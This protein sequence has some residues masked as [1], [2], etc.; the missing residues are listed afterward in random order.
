[1]VGTVMSLAPPATAWPA[2]WTPL[3]TVSREVRTVRV[4]RELRPPL[5]S[6]ARCTAL[7]SHDIAP[8]PGRRPS[9][10]P[11]LPPRTLVDINKRRAS[12]AR[13]A[14][15]RAEQMRRCRGALPVPVARCGLRMRAPARNLDNGH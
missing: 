15:T 13:E 12:R 2:W 7:R 11:P 14:G 1:V 9:A 5:A 8:R 4:R 3:T 6:T 10:S